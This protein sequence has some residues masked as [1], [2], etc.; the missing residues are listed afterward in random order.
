MI[1]DATMLIANASIAC[2]IVKAATV[3]L[4]IAATIIEPGILF[5]PCF[6]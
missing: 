6:L 5:N 2:P 1:V 4:N 3:V